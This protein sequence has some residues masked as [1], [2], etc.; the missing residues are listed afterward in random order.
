MRTNRIAQSLT[1]HA[2]LVLLLVTC[3]PLIV[4]AQQDKL[5][6]STTEELAA[7]FAAVPCKDRDRQNAVKALF[8]KMGASE[9]AIAV[10]S[11]KN[12]ENVVLIKKGKTAERIVIGAHYDKVSAG[13]GAVD[14]WTGIVALA[15]LYRSLKDVPGEKT[16]VFVAFGKEEIGLVGSRAM[17]EAISKEQLGQYCS[18]IN[19]DSLGLAIPQLA[20]NMSGGK[21][22]T[23]AIE[24]AKAMEMPFS[25]GYISGGDSDSSSFAA[26]KIPAITITGLSE[27]WPKILHSDK[28][29]SPKIIDL[30]VYLG[31]RLAL[32]MILRLDQSSCNAYR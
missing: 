32:A 27:D 8:Q 18:M 1:L 10:E 21:L 9:S 31:Y 30:S 7:E 17:V 16:L 26:K 12:V 4:S 24:V 23:L 13:C 11:F 28:D 19:I 2:A 14:N 20:K 3:V 6:I 29:Q 22:D 5:R 15:H 25:H